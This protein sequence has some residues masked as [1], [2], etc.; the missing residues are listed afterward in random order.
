[1]DALYER[2]V[3]GAAPLRRPHI[4]RAARP[5]PGP[6]AGGIAP[7]S[8]GPLPGEGHRGSR[9]PGDVRPDRASLRPPEPRHDAEGRPGLAPAAALRPRAEGRRGAARPLRRHD[10]RRGPRAPARARAPRSS[11]PTS[12]SR[13]SGAA[14]RRPGSRPAQADALALPVPRRASFDLATVDLRDAEPRL[15]PTGLAEL[16]RGAPPRRPARRA[17]V[18]PVR[19]GRLAP[20]PRRVQPARAAGAR[21]DPLARSRGV[22]LPGRSRWSASPRARSSRRPRAAAGFRDVRGET[23]FPGVCG[24][25]TGGARV[26]LVVAVSGASG[27][28][29][30]R[31][32]LDFLAREGAAHGVSVGP[33]LH[34]DRQAGLE[35]GDRRGAALPVQ[36]LE[37]PGLHRAVR[38]RLRALRRRWW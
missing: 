23:L 10:G 7:V 33:G 31:R 15:V 18:L 34:A 14:W 32:L 1:M 25:V 27:A 13:C 19:V 17:R 2:L 29:Y 38:L 30:A 9:G 12:R 37:E 22:P 6:A 4:A 11:A 35:A 26:K 24:L 3:P 5:R 36:D 20:R 16:A 8:L 28:P 21:P